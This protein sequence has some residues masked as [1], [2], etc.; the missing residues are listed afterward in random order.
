VNQALSHLFPHN[1]YPS[2]CKN[3]SP[4]FIHQIKWRP[5]TAVVLEF[6]GVTKIARLQDVP[7]APTE[8]NALARHK[9]PKV[10][11]H[12]ASVL[13]LPKLKQADSI[14][15]S[16]S[17]AIEPSINMLSQADNVDPDLQLTKPI[18]E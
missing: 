15:I 8:N 16:N 9:L 18:N 3:N 4:I 5:K 1:N 12:A 17:F 14:P 2:F 7:F 13:E 10:S 6:S 11:T